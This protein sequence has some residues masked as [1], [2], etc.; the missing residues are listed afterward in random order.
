M[1]KQYCLPRDRTLKYN[2]SNI[3]LLESYTYQKP[4]R[5][6]C[7]YER[8]PRKRKVACSNPTS[9]KPVV[10]TGSESSTAE[11]SALGVSVTGPRR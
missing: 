1:D 8:S 5:W 6:L 9:D 4:L 2:H 10:K 11:R 7:L 3:L